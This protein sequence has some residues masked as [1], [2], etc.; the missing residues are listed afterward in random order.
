MVL[1]SVYIRLLIANDAFLRDG[2]DP[3]LV[4]LQLPLIWVILAYSDEGSAALCFGHLV[5][6]VSVL[7]LE[8]E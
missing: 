4:F 2:V 7:I 5:Q 6:C 3:Y 1:E 8:E